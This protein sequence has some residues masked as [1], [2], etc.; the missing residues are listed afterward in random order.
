M[1]ATAEN[2]DVDCQH[3][4]GYEE[5]NNQMFV[6]CD[7][8]GEIPFSTCQSCPENNGDEDTSQPDY[9]F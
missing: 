9:I 2:K 4:N 1:V 8:F 3:F 5:Y 6:V 7:K